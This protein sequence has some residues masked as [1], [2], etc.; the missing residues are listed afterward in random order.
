MRAACQAKSQGRSD[1]LDLKAPQAAPYLQRIP[2]GEKI[3]AKLIDEARK[4]RRVGRV[5]RGEPFSSCGRA[6]DCSRNRYLQALYAHAFGPRL[7]HVAIVR[8]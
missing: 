7:G 2:A 6:Q 3:R 8:V 1:G 5:A 4:T